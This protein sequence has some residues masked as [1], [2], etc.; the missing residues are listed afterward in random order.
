[1]PSTILL[2][3]YHMRVRAPCGLPEAAFDAMRRALDAP[4]FQGRLRRAVR[5]V[6]GHEPALEQARVSLRP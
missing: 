5:R 1:V 3:E 6:F 4:G 2:D